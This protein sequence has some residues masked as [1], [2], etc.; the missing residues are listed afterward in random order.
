MASAFD[1]EFLSDAAPDLFTEFGAAVTHRPLN[2]SAND[3]SVTA[4]FQEMTPQESAERGKS[5]VRR[6]KVTVYSTVSLSVKDRWQIS[7]EWWEAVSV[8]VL[9]GG[10]SEVS[11][12]RQEDELRSGRKT[13]RMI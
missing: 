4:I 8:R 9:Q 2:D 7:S 5:V 10:I 13:A 12:Q 3:A 11:V 1:T 6:G